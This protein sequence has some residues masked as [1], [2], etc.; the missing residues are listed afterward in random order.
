[1]AKQTAK[2]TAKDNETDPAPACDR[3]ALTDD[4][5]AESS[6][7][8]EQL[9]AAVAEPRE[10]DDGYAFRIDEARLPF[11]GVARWADLERRCCPF[12]RIAIEI[13]PAGALWLRLT[14]G[15]EVKPFLAAELA[16]MRTR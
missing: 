6:R 2:Q 16:A 7:L 12:F 3:D 13:E 5:R 8:L 11:A 4:E 14:G 1:M 15:K 10:L 9:G